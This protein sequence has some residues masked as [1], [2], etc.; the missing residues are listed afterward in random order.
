M[1]L[2]RKSQHSNYL[3]TKLVVTVFC[4]GRPHA[5]GLQW[6]VVISTTEVGIVTK[7]DLRVYDPAL[8]CHFK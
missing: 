2:F 3:L 7:G 8:T 5:S 4:L 6:W 1:I